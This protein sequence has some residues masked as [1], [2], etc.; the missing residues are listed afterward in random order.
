MEKLI[1]FC[2]EKYKILIPVMVVIVLLITIFF[3]YKEYNYENSKQ[4]EE[5][6]V[7]QY[8]GGIKTEYTAVV[9]YNLKDAIV[10]LDA[11]DKK[12]EY[13]SKPVYYMDS[14]KVLFPNEMTAVFPLKDSGQYRLYK[15]ATYYKE[16][17]LHYIKNNVDLDNVSHFFLYDGKDMFFFPE[18]VVLNINGKEYKKLGEMSYVT[19]VG[20]LTLIY[21]DT[22][23]ETSE[24][25]ELDN[26]VV[27][28]TNDIINLN[29]NERN[30]LSFGKKILLFRPNNLNPLSKMIDK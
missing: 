20:G 28:V 10:G 6:N 18:E 26:D 15:Y 21:Y 17:E 14:K 13:D 7:Y 19:V 27:T 3:L 4:K 12:I 25:I 30:Y 29:I 23:T 11:K 5:V 9:T 2:K 1:N 8:Y 24:V 22:T 16:D